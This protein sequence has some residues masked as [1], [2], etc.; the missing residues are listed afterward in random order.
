MEIVASG[1]GMSSD[2][3]SRDGLGIGGV[4]GSVRGEVSEV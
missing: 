4:E 3:G 1:V 2:F